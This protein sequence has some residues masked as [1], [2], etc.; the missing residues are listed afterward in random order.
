[1]CLASSSSTSIDE[2]RSNVWRLRLRLRLRRRVLLKK[3]QVLPR[4]IACGLGDEALAE[5]VLE[6]RAVGESLDVV[7]RARFHGGLQLALRGHD[8][9]LEQVGRLVAAERE[10]CGWATWEL[11][12]TRDGAT[13]TVSAS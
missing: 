6:W 5:R 9:A 7:E 12:P 2:R 10:C 1:M 11:E 3:L 13:L 4:A 8:E